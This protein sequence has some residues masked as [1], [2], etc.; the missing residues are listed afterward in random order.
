MRPAA[1]APS[2]STKAWRCIWTNLSSGSTPSTRPAA[3][4]T[5]AWRFLCP[6]SR[7]RLM[8]RVGSTF[9][10]GGRARTRH[11]N[12]CENSAPHLY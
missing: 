8:P 7:R 4:A 9:A 1:F 2:A 10:V 3:M 12:V 5:A 6:N 11:S